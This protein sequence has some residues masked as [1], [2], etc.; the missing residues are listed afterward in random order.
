VT[1]T[2]DVPLLPSGIDAD[3]SLELV[4]LLERDPEHVAAQLRA[5]MAEEAA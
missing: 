3:L 2:A 5:W 1:F 4:A